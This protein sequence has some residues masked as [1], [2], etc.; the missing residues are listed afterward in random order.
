MLLAWRLSLHHLTAEEV[1]DVTQE[2]LFTSRK[3]KLGFPLVLIYADEV[4]SAG[5]L[6]VAPVPGGSAGAHNL[7]LRFVPALW[8]CQFSFLFERSFS[9]S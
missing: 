3:A 9:F 1:E 4:H 2:L 8:K 6:V 7:R 5:N